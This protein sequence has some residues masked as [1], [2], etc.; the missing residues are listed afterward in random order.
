M[1]SKLNTSISIIYSAILKH[2]YI[3]FSLDILEY[4]EIAVLIG[5]EQYYLD[6][7]KPK[8]NILKVANSR[9]GSKQSEA[10]KIKISI[11]QTGIKHHFYGKTHSYETRKKIGLSL[12]SIIRVNNEPKVITLE[13][14]LLRSLRC[15]GVSVKL[16]DKDNNFVKEFP[17]MISV[18]K[19]FNVST[20]TIGRYLDRDKKYNGFSFKSNLRN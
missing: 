18:G 6:L 13:T 14:R 4:C 10:T 12:K 17:T 19:Y 11:S 5:R 8:Y 9:L 16:F 15:K 7:L 1:L 20:R 3:N 2:G